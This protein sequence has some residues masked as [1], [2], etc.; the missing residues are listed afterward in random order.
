[1]EE[2]E[3]YL[4]KRRRK[5]IGQKYLS[6]ELSCNQSLISKFEKD[7][8]TMSDYRIRKYKEIIDN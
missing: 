5:G 2:K 6:Q 7:K 8:C 4:L 1:M 3:L